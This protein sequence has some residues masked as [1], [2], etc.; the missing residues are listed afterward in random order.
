M[1]ATVRSDVIIPE[2]FTPYVIEQTTQRD[3]FLA[4]G[5]VQPLTELNASESGGDFVNVPFWKANLSGDFE[6]LSDSSSLTVGNI[7]ADKQVGVVLHR[8]RAFEARD[9]AALAAGSDPMAAIG[10]K[11][12]AYIANQ[13][14]KD[15]VQCLS[16]VFGSLNANTNASAFFDLTIDSATADTPTALSPRHVAEARAL[17]GDQGDKLTAVAMHSKV[18][19][20]LVERRAI[21]YVTAAEARQT[22]LGT[23]EDAFGGSTA[24]AYGEVSVPTYMGLRVIISD[25]V[26]TAGSGAS[27]EYGTYFFTQGAVASGEQAGVNIETD[28]DIL[29]KSDA[30]SVDLHYIYHPVGAKWAVTTANPTRAQ[31]ATATNWSKVYELKN[32]GMVRAT[33]V[34]NMD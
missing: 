11:M 34:S 15:L 21:D 26:E 6:V 16:G 23:A 3:A 19:Y 25:D 30:M 7:T 2:I 31:L 27:T 8:G 9:L 13:R 18:Y 28:R 12:G 5:V 32:I 29:A 24:G 4:S 33:N 14:Q 17:L 10:A 20:D 1:A 22:A